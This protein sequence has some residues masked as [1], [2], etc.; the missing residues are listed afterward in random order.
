MR[1]KMS[2]AGKGRIY[3]TFI[4]LAVLFSG[5]GN[6]NQSMED[7]INDHLRK[8]GAAKAILTF[9]VSRTDSAIQYAG[10]VK[11]GAKTVAIT[12][13][14][15]TDRSS[16]ITSIFF[17]GASISPASGTAQNFTGPVTYPVTAEDNSSQPYTVTV[18]EASFTDKTI[19]AFSVS[20]SS[21][22][23]QYAGKIIPGTSGTPDAIS[24]I[25]PHG[26][27]RTRLVTSVS[28][29]GESLNHESGEKV[30]FSGDLPVTYTVWAGDGSK[31]DY[32][33]TVQE[34]DSD[35]KEITGFILAG[36]EGTINEATHTIVVAVPSGTSLTALAPTTIAYIGKSV[37]PGEGEAQDFSS[38][39]PYTV[40]AADDSTQTYLVTVKQSQGGRI[41]VNFTGKPEDE[42]T[43]LTGHTGAA[44]W[45]DKTIISVSVPAANFPG[46]DFRWYK[47]GQA[48]TDNGPTFGVGG[49]T[50]FGAETSSLEISAR[51]FSIAR[52][53]ELTVMIRM[54]AEVVYSKTLTFEVQ[55]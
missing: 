12:V 4:L 14:Y 7:Y 24:I 33:V 19:V 6:F 36:S 49:C 22:S 31:Q 30:D 26:T 1:H 51:E 29:K 32:T 9:S 37:S 10:I 38:P 17:K 2:R 8:G 41:T 52:N 46:A 40:R 53:H 54:S 34:A 39:V 23:I 18:E 27:D 11:E 5:C 35:V 21:S 15:G 16:F 20:V 42:T 25:V 55:E 50:I 3:I 45:I 47:D 43:A 48:L 44:S 13:P 28:Y